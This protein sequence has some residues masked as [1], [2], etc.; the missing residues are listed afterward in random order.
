MTTIS[1]FRDD[2]LG[3]DDAVELSTKLQRG[4]VSARELTLAA[5]ER[6]ELANPTLNATACLQL[7]R[8]LDQARQLEARRAELTQFAGIPSFLKDNLDLQGLPTRHGSSG[9]SQIIKDQSSAFTEQLAGTGLVFLGKTRLPEF[10]LTATTEFSRDQPTRNP[11]STQHTTGGS[12]G[13]SAALVAAGVVPIAH[14]NDGGGSIRIPASCCGLVGLKPSRGRTALNEMAQKLPINIVSDGVV[15]RT[16]RDTAATMA[17]LERQ[18]KNPS[19]PPLGWLQNPPA[20][21]LKIGYFTSKVTG[22]SAH[23]DCVEAV[24]LTAKK[25]EA[26]GHHVEPMAIPI[27]SQFA[28]DFLLYWGMLAA[29]LVHFGKLAVDRQFDSS[30]LE[31][32]TYGL[33]RHFR[34]NLLRFPFALNRLKRFK[35]DYKNVFSDYDVLL[36]PTL[37]MPPTLLGELNPRIEFEEVREKLIGFAAYTAAQNVAGAPGISLPMHQSAEGLPIGVHFSGPLGYEATLIELAIELEQAYPFQSL[38]VLRQAAA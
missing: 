16:V 36:S 18:Y 37:G 35:L 13:G 2:A 4:K 30:R 34:K 29:S 11:W 8:A 27:Q 15:T 7:E 20:K 26:L 25:C 12:S 21:R 33:A 5:I 14:A 10:G 9:T 32:L 1:T 19:L 6:L 28:D 24:E 22:G 38:P 17:F 3:N 31:P 23:P